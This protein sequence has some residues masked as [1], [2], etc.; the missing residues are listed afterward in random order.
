MTH[1]DPTASRRWR[2][3]LRAR[4]AIALAVGGLAVS[5]LLCVLSY[6]LARHYLVEKRLEL[7][8][9]E[10]VLNARFVGDAIGSDP[11]SIADVLAAVSDP[12]SPVLVE[13]DGRWYGAVVGFGEADLS[14]SIADAASGGTASVQLTS[15][16]GQPVA[17]VGLPLPSAGAVFY[18]S[19]ALDE[20]DATLS[21]IRNAL[22][23][24]AGVTTIG[25]AL[26]G[27]AVSRRVMRPL[28]RVADTA[29]QITD[30]DLSARLGEQDD[31][32]L[33]PL[34]RAFDEMTD[35]LARRIERERRF[36]ADVSHELRTPLTAMTSA[37]HVVERRAEELSAPGRQAVQV[38][39]T[40]VDRFSALVL[41][42]LE[43]S[44]LESDL[45]DVHFEDVDL[46]V[47]LR[48]I[49]QECGL[50]PSVVDLPGATVLR[51]RTD[52][53]RLRVIVRNLVENAN[54]YGGGCT[55]IGAEIRDGRLAVEVDDAGPGVPADRRLAVF[56]RF[57]RGEAGSNV[58][59]SG[60][61][62]SLV[63]ENA[64]VLG[65]D[66][67]VEE[68]PAG[69]A[70]FVVRLPLSGISP[71]IGSLENAGGAT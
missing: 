13:R 52:P 16:D 58:G 59:G 25:S 56:E 54:L 40:Q 22:A 17:L 26:L 67:W 45:A 57:H 50:V 66:S 14:P 34:T 36:A 10:A 64:R 37:V 43:L 69:G 8:R 11:R 51:V 1:R 32:D 38:L 33:E 42:I 49:A 19:F 63:A 44:R 68:A 4:T 21:A 46:A 70:R 48:T 12:E 35:E 65:G 55:R 30:G 15:R 2:V 60:L 20:L 24:G 39:G 18:Q 71:P 41:E 3:G 6:E 5:V 23:I 9:R 31:P 61:G 62:L 7:V 29:E 53:R 28:R 27:L 47:A